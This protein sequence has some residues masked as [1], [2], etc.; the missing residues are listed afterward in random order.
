MVEENPYAYG[1]TL[2]ASAT[3]SAREAFIRRTYTHLAGAICAFVAIEAALIAATPQ[4]VMER[5]LG[6]V[7]GFGWLAVLAAFMLVSWVARAWAQSGSSRTMQYA[8]LG[9]YVFAEALIFLPIMWIATFYLGAEVPLTAGLI[10][11]VATA[12]ITAFVFV[13]RVDLSWMG[14]YLF[15][16]GLVAIGV[17]VCAV[18]FQGFSLGILFSALMVGLAIGYILYDTSNILHHYRTDQHVAA[19]LA[20]FASVA[21]L[22]WYVLQIVMH[23]SSDD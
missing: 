22:L 14:K 6:S 19:S 5:V 21:L 18:I 9:L 2:A 16:A 1:A 12:G 4:H 3:E 11:L 15:L 7:M 8:G 13:T 17:I 20:L 10:T 23:F